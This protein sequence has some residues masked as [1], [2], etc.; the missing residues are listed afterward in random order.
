MAWVI[1]L[2][3]GV[4]EAAWATALGYTE[5]FRRILPTVIFAVA[6]VASLVGLALAMREIPVGTA[7]AVWV[8]VGAALT[9]LYPV[10]RGSEQF[11]Y[12]RA[13]LI[14]TLVAGIVGVK[15]VA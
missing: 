10:L 5:G 8:G 9:A 12:V 14:L 3:A 4:C 15:V 13:L 11:S 1:L 2:L 6:M 7:Y